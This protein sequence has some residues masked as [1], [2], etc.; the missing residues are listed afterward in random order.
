MGVGRIFSRGAR[1][2]FSQI[3][4]QGGGQ[5]WWNLFSTPRN[6]KNNLFSNNFKIQGWDNPPPCPHFDAHVCS[7]YKW[8][9]TFPRDN[10]LTSEWAV[11]FCTETF[12]SFLLRHFGCWNISVIC[13]TVVLKLTITVFLACTF[14]HS[15]R[16]DIIFFRSFQKRF[17]LW[18]KREWR[19][20]LLCSE[21][22]SS[23][24]KV[25]SI[26]WRGLD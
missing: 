17:C 7:S 3:F 14:W 18:V 9:R 21:T 20:I 13:L 25:N 2:V 22:I 23:Q 24:R 5:N 11:F 12:R 15:D 4:F 16:N 6:W 8:V 1:R 10:H 26:V 19:K